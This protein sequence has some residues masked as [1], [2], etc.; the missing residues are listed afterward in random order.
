MQPL[1]AWRAGA[2]MH[3]GI[4]WFS[5]YAIRERQ[6]SRYNPNFA[7]CIHLFCFVFAARGSKRRCMWIY[8]WVT[9]IFDFTRGK[10]R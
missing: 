7:F 5:T 8:K 9:R 6:R 4:A 1:Q 2:I 3:R 10:L